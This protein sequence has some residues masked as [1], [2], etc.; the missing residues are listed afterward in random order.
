MNLWHIIET[1]LWGWNEVLDWDIIDILLW[2]WN[3]QYTY[4]PSMYFT[5]I[6]KIIIEGK[7]CLSVCVMLY[8][9]IPKVPEEISKQIF[10]SWQWPQL[11]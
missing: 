8:E 2:S 11:K 7:I 6:A 4:I 3:K 9:T 5:F 1:W 10:N